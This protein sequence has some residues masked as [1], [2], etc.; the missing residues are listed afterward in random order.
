MRSQLNAAGDHSDI[1]TPSQRG[2]MYYY[3]TPNVD[4]LRKAN[5]IRYKPNIRPGPTLWC[6]EHAT[7]FA[8]GDRKREK[9]QAGKEN[10]KRYKLARQ[11]K[12]GAQICGI[13]RIVDDMRIA[14]LE[15]FLINCA[16]PDGND[17]KKTESCRERKQGPRGKR[18]R[19]GPLKRQPKLYGEKLVPSLHHQSF[20]ARAAEGPLE[21]EAAQAYLDSMSRGPPQETSRRA[22]AAEKSHLIELWS[23][24][25]SES[26]GKELARSFGWKKNK[27]CLNIYVPSQKRLLRQWL[28]MAGSCFDLDMLRLQGILDS[29]TE[30]VQAAEP[31]LLQ[32]G[33]APL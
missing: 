20:V 9:V 23:R 16:K 3:G 14:T 22:A 21:S 15:T 1:S 10:R 18:R 2:C 6:S 19:T 27:G 33:G 24:P 5:L 30:V 32:L 7:W 8:R 13:L 12:P 25:F 31:M 29:L 4:Y 26:Y 17:K 11:T 28:A